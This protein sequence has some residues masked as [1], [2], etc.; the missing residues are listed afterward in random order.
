M[1]LTSTPGK[2]IGE[3]ICHLQSRDAIILLWHS[4]AILK[5]LHIWCTSPAFVSPI[6]PPFDNQMMSILSHIT[7]IYF[8]SEESAWLLS[9]CALV[10]LENKKHCPFRMVCIIGLSWWSICAYMQQLR[11]PHLSSSLTRNRTSHCPVEGGSSTRHSSARHGNF[12]CSEVLAK[13]RIQLR[14]EFLLSTCI[15]SQSMAWLLAV[16]SKESENWLP[17]LCH[18]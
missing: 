13:P 15:D 9:Q 18:H 3:R 1:T 5:L 8:H 2:L 6:I 10:I 12:P 11:P 4:F 17:R 16:W 7:N 14:H